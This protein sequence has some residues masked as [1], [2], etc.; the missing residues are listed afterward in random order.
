MVIEYALKLLTGQEDM[1]IEYAVKLLTGQEDM[2]MSD[3]DEDDREL[4][5]SIAR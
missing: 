3:P 1:V 2:V 5:M 4:R